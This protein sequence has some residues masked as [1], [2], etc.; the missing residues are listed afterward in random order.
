MSSASQSTSAIWPWIEL[1]RINIFAG[2]MLLFWP[3][4]WG[5]TMSA[6]A[7][8]MPLTT[9]AAS[10]AYGLVF[11]TVLHSAMCVW[12]DILDREFDRLVER[13]KY[14]PI[15]DGRISVPGALAFLFVHLVVIIA[16][17]WPLNSLAWNICLITVFPLNG[18]YPLMKRITNWPQAWLGLAHNM[19]ALVSWSAVQHE[20]SPAAFA[21]LAGCWSWT[22]YFDTIYAC[23]D[24]RDD[25]SAGV[26]STA[27]LFGTRVKAALACF[28]ALIAGGLAASGHL[29]AQGPAFYALAVGGAVLHLGWQL[30]GLDV[31]N[32][33]SCLAAFEK[34][35]FEF[36]GIVW[37]GL[38]VDYLLV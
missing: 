15:A 3:Y 33:R 14:R 2:T 38:V 13:T 22:L 11:A 27:L 37:A 10:I 18:I 21:L 12:N 30:G 9:Y 7:V 1:S 16:L 32:A 5:L 36:G 35:G 34:N 31:D 26:K 17:M 19:L 6:R 28:A 24:K 29:G 20:I 4:A 8:S 25:V 23:Q